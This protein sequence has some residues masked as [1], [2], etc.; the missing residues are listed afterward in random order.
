M[1]A[2]HKI[3]SWCGIASA[4]LLLSAVSTASLAQSVTGKI[5]ITVTNNDPYQ[6]ISASDGNVWLTHWNGSIWQWNNLSRP[7]GVGVGTGLGANNPNNTPYAYMTGTDGNVWLTHWNGSGWPWTNLSNPGSTYVAGPVAAISISNVPYLFVRGGDG[8]LWVVHWN[9]SG[10]PWNNLGKPA[11]GTVNVAGAIGG[12]IFNNAP[13]VFLIGSDGAVYAAQWNGSTWYFGGVGPPAAGVVAAQ[14]VGAYP[15]SAY[16][17][18]SDGNLWETY[19]NG[20]L[21]K[22]ANQSKPATAN[23]SKPVGVTQN[24]SGNVSVHVI[25]DN[26]HLYGNPLNNPGWLDFGVV[27]DGSTPQI[28]LGDASTLTVKTPSP[29]TFVGTSSGAVWILNPNGQW[30]NANFP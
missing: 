3:A 12:E 5:G 15:G 13:F 11:S 30:G 8:N 7:G 4:G 29:F 28:A 24:S 14:G 10:W 20:T 16:V 22:W 23:L 19:W 27:T 26:G 25:G 9:G 2:I 17:I 18:G 6:F 21:W 1:G